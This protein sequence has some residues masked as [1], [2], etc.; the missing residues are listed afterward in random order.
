MICRKLVVL[1]S[2]LLVS[3]SVTK[4][5]CDHFFLHLCSCNSVIWWSEQGWDWKHGEE[6]WE[7]CRWRCQE[8]GELT[9]QYFWIE[10]YVTLHRPIYKEQSCCWSEER[11][12][13]RS[14]L[15]WSETWR[16][17]KP[18]T[19]RPNLLLSMT[20]WT[21]NEKALTVWSL[22]KHVVF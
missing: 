21:N 4:W 12:C 18:L 17:A 9:D 6:C 16:V 13:I 1:L 15:T 5:C 11:F 2:Q 22:Y 14:E 19:G 3:S 10:I 8:K 7:I 20:T